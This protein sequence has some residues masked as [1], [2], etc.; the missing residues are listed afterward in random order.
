MTAMINS[1]GTN[2]GDPYWSQ[3]TLLMGFDGSIV[4]ES[5][6]LTITTFN[7]PP[8]VSSPAQPYGSA[9]LDLSSGVNEHMTVAESADQFYLSADFT[10]EFTVRVTIF[11]SPQFSGIFSQYQSSNSQ[12][13]WYI[14]ADGT[15]GT[16]RIGL[17]VSGDGL[18]VVGIGSAAADEVGA[19]LTTGVIYRICIERAGNTWRFYV[20]GKAVST[21]T[22]SQAIFNSS[23]PLIIGGHNVITVSQYFDGYLDEVRITNGRARYQGDYT[24]AVS[25]FPRH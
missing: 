21:V 6:G 5:G 2:P 13:A 7:G 8:T 4:D 16:N 1:Y 24:V 12:R 20:N 10:I 3:V 14:Y 23:E 25:K 18:N 22:S 19:A 9:W 15:G 17:N 11:P